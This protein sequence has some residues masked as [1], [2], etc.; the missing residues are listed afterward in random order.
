MKDGRV[1]HGEYQSRTGYHINKQGN[2]KLR[3]YTIMYSCNDIIGDGKYYFIHM[4]EHT[5]ILIPLWVF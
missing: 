1:Y 3:S 2:G 5:Y 4:V